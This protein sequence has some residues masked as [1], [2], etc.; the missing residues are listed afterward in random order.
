MKFYDR[1]NEV[2]FLRKMRDEARQS[3]RFT[4]LKGRRR[5]G[6]TSLLDRAYRDEGYLYF[7]VARKNEADLCLDFQA[8]IERFF[9]LPLPGRIDS[10]EAVFKYLMEI[11]VQRSFTVVID[12]FQEFQR[13][14][15]S[16]FSTMQRDWDR[17]KHSS[18]INLVVSGSIN[19][20]MD[21]IF[22]ADQP[23]FGRS[24]NGLTLRP[25]TTATLK[26]ILKDHLKTVDN[27]AL[28]ALWSL[29]GGVA[30]YVE[31]LME[32]S[33]F[34]LEKMVEAFV[35]ED[36]TI[37]G[38]GKVL[39][40]EEFRKDYGTYF[41]ILSLIASGRTSRS[42]I[43]NVIGSDIGGY[44]TKLCDSYAI[45][46][47]KTPFATG[48]SHRNMLYQIEDNFLRFWFRFIYKYQA[49]IELKAY[50]RLRSL[51]VRDY[52]V[53]S[54]KALEQYFR[55][56]LAESGEW[57]DIGNWYDRKGENE[58]DI[59]AVD[60]LEK[61]IL[62]AEVKRNS[63][64]INP[65]VLEQRAKSFLKTVPKYEEYKRSYAAYSLAD[66]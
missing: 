6:K 9:K 63:G 34:S 13:V 43:E 10:F 54:G 25:F 24:T 61:R 14:N 45:L 4:I 3:A 2:A 15:P 18:K 30:K 41:S 29:T 50:S 20:M 58:I 65:R 59:V 38:E 40:V 44:L 5:V 52:T 12:E 62:F 35:S 26:K 53:F 27:E 1:E 19:R 16:I 48:G 55:C 39:L 36:S 47:K 33:A 64:K 8:E 7:F 56:K 11:S 37:P 22:A 57:T 49:A 21:Q 28:L 66:M 23:L 51:I 32:A 60:D 42:E 31:T 17:L 46:S